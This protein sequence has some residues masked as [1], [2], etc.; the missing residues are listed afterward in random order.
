MSSNSNVQAPDQRTL[1]WV[2]LI[3]LVYAVMW[4]S[5]YK[6]T[7]LGLSPALDNQQTL[8]L[9]QQMAEGNL[10]QE[11]FHRAPFYPS[12]LS[13]FLKIGIEFEALPILAR[14]LNACALLICATTISAASMRLWKNTTAGWISGLLVGLNPVILFFAGDPFDIL[15]AT[16]C[17]CLALYRSVTWLENPTLRGTLLIGI[18]LTVGSALRS[19][20]LPLALMWPVVCLLLKQS[21]KWS[22]FSGAAGPLLL[23]FILL[24]I[25]NYK[26]ANEFRMLP[27]QG[28]YNLWAGNGP[29]ASG[30]IYT[31]QIRVEFENSYDNPAKLESIKLYE[32]E[33]GD[34]PPHSI[35]EMNAYWKGKAI[36]HIQQHPVDWIGLMARKAYYFLNN[37]EQY[38]NKT[39]GL[40]KS[41]HW[42]LRWNP[43]HW[44]A[45]LLVAVAGTIIGL[46]RTD[47]KNRIFILL[48]IAF[49][50]YAAGTIWFYTPNRFRVPMIPIL[51]LL[52]GGI[53]S[54]KIAWLASSRSWKFAFLSCGLLTSMIAYS[55][56]FNATDRNTWEE[57]YALLANASIRTNQDNDA[58]QWANKAL[59]MNPRRE[60]MQDT[61]TQA[62]F[63]I[64]ALSDSPQPLT[65]DRAKHLRAS[66]KVSA[67]T[68][69][70]IQTI[71]GIYDWKLGHGSTALATWKKHSDKYPFARLCLFWTG[72]SDAPSAQELSL[73]R[74]NKALSLLETAIIVKSA[75]SESLV[76]HT[77]DNIFA[78]LD[79][80]VSH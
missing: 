10:L 64:W 39:Y 22:H 72:N 23:S 73:Y 31:Q 35:S 19:H 8:L 42:P 59:T 53:A 9:A 62:N 55:S 74:G 2:A 45:L 6:H 40:H 16:A 13:I 52:S 65:Q 60:D 69:P 41:I 57:D 47:Q 15:P 28:A 3:T 4:L 5:Y 27:W 70:D 67:S 49:T 38:D 46:Q 21:R 63:N 25:A 58:I 7:P 30:K 43:I 26:V 61:I 80:P 68:N 11:P 17:L 51:C 18:Y 12:L 14:I 1:L 71:I 50:L 24:G 76:K 66:A 54:L 20:L 56:W 33:T 34:H 79:T 75:S 77:I 78:L 44:G 29:L 48:I 32:L 37:Y 36:D